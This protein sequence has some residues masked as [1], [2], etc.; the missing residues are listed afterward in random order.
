VL[1]YVNGDEDLL[2][3]FA[4][5]AEVDPAHVVAAEQVLAETGENEADG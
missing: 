4:N 1:E 3:A 5:Y 2:L